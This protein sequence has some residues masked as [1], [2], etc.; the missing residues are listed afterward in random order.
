M[1]KLIFAGDSHTG[2]FRPFDSERHSK[3]FTP[4]RD[5]TLAIY[6]R[7]ALTMDSFSRGSSVAYREL[8]DFLSMLNYKGC[9]LILCL[10]EVDLRVHF[11]RDMPL[12]ESRGISFEAFL[13]GK[14][15]RF[16]ERVD[17]LAYEM[18]LSSIILWGAPASQMNTMNSTFELPATGD[19]VTRNILTHMLNKCIL[20]AITTRPTKL[21]FSTPFYGMISE[22]FETDPT[23][24]HDGVHLNFALR[25]FCFGTLQ[26]VIDQT[27]LATFGSKYYDFE[28]AIFEYQSIARDYAE[29]GSTRFFRT[30]IQSDVQSELTLENA[31][32]KFALVRSIEEA[33][34][35]SEYH[36]LVLRKT[37]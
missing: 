34:V 27:A 13:Q 10:S 37:V 30:W 9:S 28:P 5:D 2:I 20:K 31:F 4:L 21:R 19:S 3:I 1:K 32:G 22:D 29:V 14:V 8:V 6:H 23:W 26:Q 35:K 16:I 7:G 15:D 17:A 11:W 33:A 18:Q 24:L 36:E 25:E 12:L